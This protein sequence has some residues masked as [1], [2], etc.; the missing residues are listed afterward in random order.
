LRST[1]N[2]P[3]VVRA[4]PGASLGMFEMQASSVSGSLR[5][6]VACFDSDTR[7]NV[8]VQ[9]RQDFPLVGIFE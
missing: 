8:G 9:I 2:R 4:V 5:F 6:S 7:G 1:L 3:Q